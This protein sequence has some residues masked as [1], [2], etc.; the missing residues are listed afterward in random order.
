[1]SSGSTAS[2]YAAACSANS[3]VAWPTKASVNGRP[4]SAVI[5]TFY[6]PDSSR[7]RDALH[8]V[9]R[10][11]RSQDREH[12]RQCDEPLG[13]IR[14]DRVVTDDLADLVVHRVELLA[15]LGRERL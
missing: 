3:G 10:R 5:P 7:L 4:G 15:A 12:K 13:E 2:S 14:R 8:P 6:R 1:M 9:E 11:A